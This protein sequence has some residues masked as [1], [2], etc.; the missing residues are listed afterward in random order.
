MMSNTES[1]TDI[2]AEI[3]YWEV[4][5][6]FWRGVETSYPGRRV[7]VELARNTLSMLRS[8]KAAA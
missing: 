1:V 6:A 4:R 7:A 2:N 8:Q 3:A 5:F